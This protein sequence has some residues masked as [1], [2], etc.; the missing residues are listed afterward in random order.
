MKL[1]G[2]SWE[3]V[4][5]ALKRAGF[6]IR[7]DDGS[8]IILKSNKCPYNLSIPRHREVAPFLLRK[9]LKLAGI[10]IKEFEKLLKKKKK[11]T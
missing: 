1:V 10:S 7:N 3:K 5:T 2:L 4:V 11:R 9:Q 6:H 8:H